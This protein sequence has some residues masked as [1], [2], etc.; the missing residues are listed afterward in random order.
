M[1]FLPSYSPNLNLIERLWRKKIQQVLRKIN[2]FKKLG[3]DSLRISRNISLN[4]IRWWRIIFNFGTR[5]NLYIDESRI[6]KFISREYG[7]GAKG[8]KVVGEISGRRY[9]RESFVEGRHQNKIIAPFCYKGTCDSNL[10][11]FWLENF[12][13]P[14]LGPGYISIMHNATFHKSEQT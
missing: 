5:I 11:N 4:K 13:L 7:R 1:V 14:V 10:F 2:V 9:T 6:D 3:L 12:L 8:A